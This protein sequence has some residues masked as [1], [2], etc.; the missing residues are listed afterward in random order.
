MNFLKAILISLLTIWV[1]EKLYA[2]IKSPKEEIEVI[3]TEE[4]ITE[5]TLTL[6]NKPVKQVIAKTRKEKFDI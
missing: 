5:E 2:Y 6:T 3:N 4:S 1:M